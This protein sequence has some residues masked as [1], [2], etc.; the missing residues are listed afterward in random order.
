MTQPPVDTGTAAPPSSRIRAH[1]RTLLLAAA[2]VVALGSLAAWYHYSGRETTDDAQIDGRITPIA[3]RVGGTVLSVPVRDNQLVGA[4]EPLVQIDPRDYRVSLAK[5]QADF[6]DAQAALEAARAGVPIVTTTTSGQVTTS[7]ATVERAKAG[8][9]IAGKDVDAARARLESMRAR[10]RESQA[11][12]SKASKDLERMKQLIAK[13]EISQQQ[14]DAAVAGAE[15]A[16]AA[17]D[18]ASAAVAEAEQAVSSAESRRGQAVDLGRQAEAELRTAQTAP[19]QV[20]VTRARAASAEAR[21]AQA[22]AQ[23]DQAQMNVG[24]T[25]I[26]SPRAGVVSKKSV[27]VGQVVQAGQPLMAIVPLDDVWV[28][29]NFKET[30]LDEVRPGQ[31]AIVRVDMY[32]RTWEGRVESIAPAT[33]ARFSLL[34]PENA[35]GNYV[36]VVQRI[37]VKI[38]LTP[39]QD[40]ERLLRPGMS[41]V[42]TVITQ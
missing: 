12:R 15:A 26:T 6:A 16:A 18:S 3:A 8:V 5:A 39:G 40:R 1:A 17:V 11:N 41:V 32:G 7:T 19:S 2:L 38:V 9:A 4:G 24:Y 33:G 37:P 27:E 10:L 25:L 21:V 31:R 35:T 20:L 30:Q 42:A 13:D 23:L 28:T 34:P 29:A 36:K 22:R 14:F